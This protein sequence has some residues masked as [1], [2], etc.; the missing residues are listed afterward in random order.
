MK[1][2]ITER[3]C[4]TRVTTRTKIYD[5]KCPGLYVFISTKGV[6]TFYFKYWD[7]AAQKKFDVRIGEYHPDHMTV[8]KA[9]GCCYDLRG[10]RGNGE[11]IV[12]TTRIAKRQAAINSKTVAEI[13]DEYIEWMKEPVKKEDGEKRPRIESW[14]GIAG[15]L[16]RF[17]RPRLGAMAASEVENDDIARLQN[18]IV[19][20]K[21]SAK[22]KPSVSNARNTRTSLSGM[23]NWAAEAGRKYVKISP[24]ANLPSLDKEHSRERVLSAAEIKKVWWGLDHPDVPCERATALALKFELVSMLR[25]KEFRTGQPGEIKGRGTKD[26]QFHIPLKRVKKRHIIVTPLSDL[27]VAILDEA[28]TAKDQAY[29]FQIDGAPLGRQA[30]PHAVRGYTDKKGKVVRQGIYQ[31]LGMKPWTPHDLRRTAATLAG[32]LKFTDAE[33]ARCLDHAVDDGEDAAPTV[34]GTYVRSKRIDEKRK[35]LD[36]VADAL[37]EIIGKPPKVIAL[38]AA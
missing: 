19:K 33:I 32:D 2:N 12:Q 35:L 29:I 1:T 22:F 4:Q 37:R 15:Y 21:V 11:N 24:C 14:D 13:I 5:A 20:G 7:G 31:F 9:R 8:E 36:A 16:N 18:D 28:I 30:L 17:A 38:K 27:A 34:T 10:R 3:L 26:V 25:S 6:A 23:F